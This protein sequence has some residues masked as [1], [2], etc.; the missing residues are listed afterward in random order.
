MESQ[1]SEPQKQT[2][3]NAEALG[4][5]EIVVPQEIAHAFG[6][7][8]RQLLEKL[9]DETRQNLILLEPFSKT[10]DKIAK[11]SIVSMKNGLGKFTK[12]IDR[13]EHSRDVKIVT[14]P[15]GF[16]F[17]FS[18]GTKNF[19]LSLG[20]RPRRNNTGIQALR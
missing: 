3:V 5:K 7:G 8:L 9:T 15:G 19:F 13:L 11:G 6:R 1:S 17:K 16:D 18:E 4:Q 2:T 20:P 12:I 10:I 14:I